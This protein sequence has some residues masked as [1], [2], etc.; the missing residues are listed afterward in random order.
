MNKTERLAREFFIRRFKR[1]PEQ[2]IDYFNEWVW[3][4]KQINPKAFM[5]NE[6]KDVYEEILKE[7]NTFEGLVK[8][9][10]NR[11]EDKRGLNKNGK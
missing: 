6:S 7:R 10:L 9:K 1:K 5:D 3:R 2:D 11:I 4:F 8:E